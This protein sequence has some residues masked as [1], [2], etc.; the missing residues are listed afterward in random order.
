MDAIVGMAE[1]QE[2]DGFGIPIEWVGFDG[3]KILVEAVGRYFE[4]SCV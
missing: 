2:G 4:R 1:A 3:N